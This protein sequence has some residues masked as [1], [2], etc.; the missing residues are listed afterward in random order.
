MRLPVKFDVVDNLVKHCVDARNQFSDPQEIK[1]TKD[2]KIHH[3]QGKI[4]FMSEK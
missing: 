3:V 4:F 2:R 1:P